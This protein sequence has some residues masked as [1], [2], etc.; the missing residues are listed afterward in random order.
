MRAA[1]APARAHESPI[2]RLIEQEP[3]RIALV[4]G[5]ENEDWPQY[6][7][8]AL[9]VK[10]AVDLVGA[11]MLLVLLLPLLAL[12][13]VAI[14]LESNGPI[15]FA[16]RR[17]GRDRRLFSCL[18]FR[19]MHLNAEDLLHR[20]EAL[21]HQYVTN[22]FKIPSAHDPRITRLGRL[23][24]ESSMDELPQL[25]NVLAGDMSLVGPRPIVPL[26]ATHY[27]EQVDLLLSMRP[28]I[29][30][31]WAVNGR[32]SVGYPE[33]TAVELEYVRNWSLASDAGI[34]L[35]TPLAVVMRHGAV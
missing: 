4:E 5:S 31:A 7:L 33:R 13:A 6:S 14:K 1:E 29:T 34:L 18:K 9:A 25:L 3:I 16:H 2:Q 23:L 21:R 30:G 17:L 11:L 27:G 28:G 12:V 20:D 32:S 24:R 15:L 10:R 19:T 26:E 8:L 22:H 35:R